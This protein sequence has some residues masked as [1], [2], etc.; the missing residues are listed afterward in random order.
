MRFR[1]TWLGEDDSA[2]PPRKETKAIERRSRTREV[3]YEAQGSGMVRLERSER[4][5]VKRT[6]IANF[7]ARIDRDIIV[8]DGLQQSR[9]VGIHAELDG[10]LI[11]A[12][13]QASDFN[14]MGWVLRELGPKAIIYPGQQ[15]HARAAIQ[16]LSREIQRERVFAHLGW[17]QH[18]QKWV[19][20]Q[21]RQAITSSGVGEFPV[22]LA[23]N[24]RH[25]HVD[26]PDSAA[27]LRAIRADPL[28]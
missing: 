7:T 26:P 23:E 6:Q 17:T 1:L 8:D 18:E 4:D 27:L 20:L 24:L 15:Q 28:M 13:L 19:Y 25:Y 22:C 12:S 5:V 3:W 9:Y 16:S 14:R 11:S 2:E 10:E 21:A